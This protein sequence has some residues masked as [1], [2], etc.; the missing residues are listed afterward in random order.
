VG[1]GGG[2]RG[3]AGAP[4][5]RPPAPHAV[6]HQWLANY[7]L[8]PQALAT[9]GGF[10]EKG[11]SSATAASPPK[12]QL[13]R[14]DQPEG[15][16]SPKASPPA[17]VRPRPSVAVSPARRLVEAASFETTSA[18]P[19][20]FPGSE[21]LSRV[22]AIDLPR[23]FTMEGPPGLGS[24]PWLAGAGRPSRSRGAAGRRR[25]SAAPRARAG[26]RPALPP[27]SGS[28]SVPTSRD[29]SSSDQKRPGETPEQRPGDGDASER[30]PA[31]MVV[32]RSGRGE[33]SGGLWRAAPRHAVRRP[34][35]RAGPRRGTP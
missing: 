33:G 23:D 16:L 12:W 1:P 26:S 31:M 8:N 27:S 13:L 17:P 6:S 9:E 5:R 35:A 30:G 3:R 25:P 14:V 22:W 18:S 28:S 29:A 21:P 2:G 24:G 20:A 32:T 11:G 7:T 4:P 34:R 15:S 19:L 10:S